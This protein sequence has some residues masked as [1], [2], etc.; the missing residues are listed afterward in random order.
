LP[1]LILQNQPEYYAALRS[2]DLGFENLGEP[3]LLPLVG[4]IQRLLTQQL[5]SVP[6]DQG[7]SD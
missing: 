7:N 4:M 1:D 2:A 6:V 5:A 3:D